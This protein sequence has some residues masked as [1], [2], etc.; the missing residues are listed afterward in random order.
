MLKKETV[1]D[2]VV[3]GM[4]FKTKKEAKEVAEAKIKEINDLVEKIGATLEVGDKARLGTLEISKVEVGAKDGEMTL[5][6][7]TKKAWHKD[8]EVVVKVK[9]VK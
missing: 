4:E 3:E 9:L 1:L 5:K 7:G 8:A 2:L 6:D